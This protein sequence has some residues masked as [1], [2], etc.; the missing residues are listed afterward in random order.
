MQMCCIDHV[1]PVSCFCF[2]WSTSCSF[3]Y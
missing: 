1:T 2:H 3:C